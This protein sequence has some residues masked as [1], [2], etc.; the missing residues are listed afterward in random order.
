MHVQSSLHL[1]GNDNK[2]K[3]DH[4]IYNPKMCSACINTNW[5]IHVC[6]DTKIQRK[7]M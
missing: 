5:Y 3:L 7:G 2:N 4:Y 1:K 6:N